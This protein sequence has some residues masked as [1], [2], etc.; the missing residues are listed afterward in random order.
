ML[1]DSAR[2]RRRRSRSRSR[3]RD[4]HRGEDDRHHSRHKDRERDRGGE[5][6][7][8]RDREHRDWRGSRERV[9][10]APPP[11]LDLKEQYTRTFASAGRA[12]ENN[13]GLPA[14]QQSAHPQDAYQAAYAAYGAN[15]TEGLDGNLGDRRKRGGSWQAAAPTAT[16]YVRGVP[17]VV[18]EADFWT[19]LAPWPGVQAVRITKDRA[20]GLSR[21]FAFVDFTS[22]EEARALMEAPGRHG[23]A[24]HDEILKF[25]YSIAPQPTVGGGDGGR[26]AGGAPLDWVCGMCQAVNFSRRL[27]CYQCSTPRPSDPLRITA[28]P[29]APS[30]VLKV[31]GLEPHISEEVLEAM[32]AAVVPV[33]EVRGVRDKFTG[34]PRGFC[35]LHLFSIADAARAMQLLQG[36]SVE[37]QASTLR[38]CYARERAAPTG[39]AADA[40]DAAQAMS[41]YSAWEPKE[42][43]G[44]EPEPAAPG[45]VP[46]EANPNPASAPAASE[47]YDPFARAAGAPT[48]GAAMG[49]ESAQAGFVYDAASG[50]YYDAHSGYYYD[51]NS[52]LYF[53]SSSQCWLAQDPATGEYQ[54]YPATGTAAQA[55]DSV[56]T[57][58]QAAAAM[59][60]AAAAQAAAQAAAL[61]QLHAPEV[62]YQPKA[63]PARKRGA[64]IGSKPQLNAQ[65]LLEHVQLNKERED[66]ARA[67]EAKDAKNA[68]AAARAS[69]VAA[70]RAAVSVPVQPAAA[71]AAGPAQAGAVRGVIR[72]SGRWGGPPRPPMAQ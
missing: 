27:E 55:A 19:L 47:S 30:C 36:A 17:D 68:R 23:L 2:R 39:A 72:S 7:R 70:P 38:L 13:G 58:A 71:P 28:E 15:L 33:R 57:A 43:D 46:Q 44:A 63:A 49:G 41:A 21:G 51:A 62:V 8:R 45:E 37:G 29:E 60:D 26:G 59:A 35:F 4:R 24:L 64:V 12:F 66:A 6:E 42:F 9:P 54:P 3:E 48:D 14:G 1:E 16:L 40:L 56:S 69:G 31:S 52:G 11:P 32:A 18:D 67:Q 50:Y 65:G 10:E 25:E 5:R 34:A 53:D 61:A 22:V 20:T